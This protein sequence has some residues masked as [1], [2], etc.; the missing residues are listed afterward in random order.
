MT[1]APSIPTIGRRE[2][3]LGKEGA[4]SGRKRG[5]PVPGRSLKSG[6]SRSPTRRGDDRPRQSGDTN[7]NRPGTSGDLPAQCAVHRDSAARAHEDRAEVSWR[8]AILVTFERTRP[9]TVPPAQQGP[10]CHVLWQ[11]RRL[12][13]QATG[14][15]FRQDRST[16]DGEGLSAL[17]LNHTSL[18]SFR[19]P[20]FHFLSFS[21]PTNK[22]TNTFN[23]DDA[24]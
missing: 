23:Q 10:G 14:L 9:A 11:P 20:V 1:T 3:T 18:L 8:E 19:H 22:Q 4:R 17:R 7:G 12:D 15:T 5:C 2:R 21:K 24:S 16:A 6:S 13:E